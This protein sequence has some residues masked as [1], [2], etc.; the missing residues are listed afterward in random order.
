MSTLPS[1]A[2]GPQAG[3]V[4]SAGTAILDSFPTGRSCR[5]EHPHQTEQYLPRAARP[6]S[7]GLPK[8]RPGRM[9]ITR[10]AQAG[11]GR[12]NFRAVRAEGRGD[13]SA[14]TAALFWL[15]MIGNCW[16]VSGSNE[17]DPCNLKPR[18]H[19]LK[20]I[21][22]IRSSLGV[23]SSFDAVKPECQMTIWAY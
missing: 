14:L 9:G 8:G 20:M 5:A 15:L 7:P 18:N 12:E 6:T 2:R 19:R 23:R 4:P 13:P 11:F 3:A 21:S 16:L 17:L 10:P 22:A 1:P